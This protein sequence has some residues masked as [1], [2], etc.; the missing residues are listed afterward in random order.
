MYENILVIDAY[1]TGDIESYNTLA[2]LTNTQLIIQAR[3]NEKRVY[4]ISSAMQGEPAIHITPESAKMGIESASNGVTSNAG[5][6]TNTV[7]TLV[8]IILLMIL[9]IGSFFV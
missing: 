2:L 4:E 8:A 1:S 6:I 7:Y 9:I 3:A 5:K